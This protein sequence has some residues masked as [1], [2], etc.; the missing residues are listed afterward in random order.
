RLTIFCTPKTSCSPAA[1]RNNTEA[2]NTPPRRTS[3]NAV[4]LLFRDE[5]QERAGSR[6]RRHGAAIMRCGL[7]LY[8]GCFD[9]LP[10][11]VRC[12][13]LLQLRRV[14][15]VYGAQ[16]GEVVLVV[17]R[18]QPLVESLLGYVVLA[19][20][21]RAAQRLDA[22]ALYRVDDIL[23]AGPGVLRLVCGFNAGAVDL[24]GEV[25]AVRFPVWIV[26]V[27]RLV[28]LHELAL[29]RASGLEIKVEGV[30]AE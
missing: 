8:L 15:G 5:Q 10:E 1:T 16:R 29:Q 27:A 11:I 20:L 14:H 22:D 21:A 7:E 26:L 13:G 24:H 25:G 6:R 17:V 19:H 12:L 3:K 18:G 4:K 2:W 28:H 23:G 9:P 30:V